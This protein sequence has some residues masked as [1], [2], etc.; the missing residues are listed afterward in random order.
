[1]KFVPDEKYNTLVQKAAHW[2]TLQAQMTEGQTEAEVNAFSPETVISAI[3]EA[4]M[5]QS[6]ENVT[7]L[8]TQVQSLSA[9]NKT[10]AAEKEVLSTRVSTLE[11]QAG[12]RKGA[13]ITDKEVNETSETGVVDESLSFA[14]N[15]NAVE[16]VFKSILS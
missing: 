15:L 12:S 1:M 8:Q 16:T 3:E 9:A 5:S 10:L 14:E 11:K 13:A 7:A 2:D 4:T 6:D